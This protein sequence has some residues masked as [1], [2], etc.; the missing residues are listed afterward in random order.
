VTIQ[1]L[2]ATGPRDVHFGRLV[3]SKSKDILLV[4]GNQSI[5]ALN[6][7]TGE[8]LYIIKNRESGRRAMWAPQTP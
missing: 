2:P 6:G 8:F 5:Q 1:E 4:Q 7:K 3:Y